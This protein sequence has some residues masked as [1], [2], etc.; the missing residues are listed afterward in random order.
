MIVS[1]LVLAAFGTPALAQTATPSTHTSS[2][3]PTPAPTPTPTTCAGN[4]CPGAT[5][6]TV[7][8]QVIFGGAGASIFEG[9]TGSNKITKNGSGSIDVEMNANGC[10]TIDCAN[11]AS[12]FKFKGL[13]REMVTVE[14]TAAGNTSGQ[15]VMAQNQGQ[16]IGAL[17]FTM[18]RL[19]GAPSPTPVP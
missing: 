16:A 18:Q 15:A 13:A 12:S 14:T 4:I 1:A 2:N 8:G 10:A 5:S 17:N 9:A 3:T 11:G 19:Q 7:G 6:W